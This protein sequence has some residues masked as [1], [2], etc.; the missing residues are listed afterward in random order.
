MLD[1]FRGKTELPDALFQRLR[2][3]LNLESSLSKCLQF[4]H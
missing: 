4:F 1:C 3:G 2:F